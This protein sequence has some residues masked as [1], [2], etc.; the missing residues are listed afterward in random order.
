MDE[1]RAQPYE[2]LDRFS[3]NQSVQGG[4]LVGLDNLDQE[5][6]NM[7]FLSGKLEALD[8]PGEHFIDETTW[9][10][11]VWAPDSG[12]PTDVR[13]KTRDWCDRG[14]SAGCR[15]SGVPFTSGDGL[16]I[17]NV[18]MQF[19]TFH[20]TV[21]PRG[22]EV[23]PFPAVTTLEGNNSV[24]SKFHLRCTQMVASRLSA[25]GIASRRR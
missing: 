21:D 12:W 7:Y 8:S 25:A 5:T 4:G 11:Y 14:N 23:G 10:M 17:T 9:T 22:T 1:A 2:R 19:P 24:V 20:K 15:C 16:S 13:V 6:D 18:S 3:Y